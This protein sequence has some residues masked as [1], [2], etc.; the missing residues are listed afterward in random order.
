MRLVGDTRDGDPR[1]IED[2]RAVPG[3][4]LTAEP[5]FFHAVVIE[6]PGFGEGRRRSPANRQR[7]R[8]DGLI[9]DVEVASSRPAATNEWKSLTDKTRNPG[10]HLLQVSG[11]LGTVGQGVQQPV[12]VV[13]D[14][15]LADLRTVGPL[16]VDS[17]LSLMLSIRSPFAPTEEVIRVGFAERVPR[18]ELPVARPQKQDQG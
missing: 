10:Q 1:V 2:G 12:D 18:E 3:R 17:A 13:E 15:V 16:V 8:F 7:I 4:T 6:Q 11:K 5:H 9:T 14:I